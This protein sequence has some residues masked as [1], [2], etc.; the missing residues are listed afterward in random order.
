MSTKAS[1]RKKVT[2]KVGNS[3]KDT[4]HVISASLQVLLTAK[5]F[6]QQTAEYLDK[7]AQEEIRAK[8]LTGV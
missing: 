1:A 7:R 2:H 6:G 4:G 5:M 8:S 3:P